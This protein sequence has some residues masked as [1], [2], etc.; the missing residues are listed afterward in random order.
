[1]ALDPKKRQKK[2]AKR[3]AQR[4][5]KNKKLMVQQ[6]RQSAYQSNPVAFAARY[7]IHECIANA[8]MFA[9]GMGTVVVSRR[10]PNGDIVMGT[11]LLDTFCLGVKSA[12]GRTLLPHEYDMMIGEMR[13]NEMMQ[14]VE[15][16]CARK[17]VEGALAYAASLGFKPDPDYYT[18]K[19]IFGDIDSSG[20][21]DEFKFGKDGKPFYVAGPLD[22]PLK[23]RQI[24]ATLE[25]KVGVGNFDF[26]MPIGGGALDYDDY[27]DGEFDDDDFEL[28]GDDDD[29]SDG[30]ASST[31][32]S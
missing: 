30:G 19:E 1:M 8:A 26:L 28:E 24:I 5:E 7:P 21:T 3:K 22:S 4:K 11:F 6:Q 12:F 20:C 32:L 27:D 9:G 14:A 13:Q 16:A 29:E 31:K 10:A 17:M 25:K 2:L 23:Q 18:A 15:P